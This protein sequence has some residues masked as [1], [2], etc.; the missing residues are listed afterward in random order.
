MHG[1]TYTPFNEHS[2][3]Q[4]A[5]SWGTVLAADA[6]AHCLA[7]K[8]V[9][10]QT[11]PRRSPGQAAP[12]RVTPLHYLAALH[13]LKRRDSLSPVEYNDAIIYCALVI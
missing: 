5:M 7:Y 12:P 1:Q 3:E 2:K 9:L 13:R 11:D 6:V 4:V 8:A 10:R